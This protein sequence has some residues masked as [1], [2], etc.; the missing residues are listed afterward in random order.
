MQSCGAES[1]RTQSRQVDIQELLKRKRVIC[2]SD[3][4]EESAVAPEL[5]C[6][7][8]TLATARAPTPDTLGTVNVVAA[9]T[10]AVADAAASSAAGAAANA[11]GDAAALAGSVTPPTTHTGWLE[12][13]KARVTGTRRTADVERIKKG[14]KKQRHTQTKLTV[15]RKRSE[16]ERRDEEGGGVNEGEDES[17]SETGDKKGKRPKKM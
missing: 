8:P 3:D 14:A 17:D 2:E 6:L 1:G 4:E 16:Q 15:V 5:A 7:V 11:A 12:R 10:A 9:A 13:S